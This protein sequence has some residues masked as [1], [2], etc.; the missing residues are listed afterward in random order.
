MA[1]WGY[2]TFTPDPGRG[3]RPRRDAL[4]APTVCGIAFR[5]A[6]PE[7]TAAVESR[8][9]DR[10]GGSAFGALRDAL[11]AVVARLDPTL[12]DCLPILGYG[13]PRTRGGR[14]AGLANPLWR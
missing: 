5:D 4:I 13:L 6:W 8:W 14:G 3:K 11:A 9:R 2:V 1:R 7:V 12:P 10:L